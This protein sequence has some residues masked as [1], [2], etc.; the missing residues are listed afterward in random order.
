MMDP[1]IRVV[2]LFYLL[3]NEQCKQ[4]FQYSKKC[5]YV[6]VCTS[7]FDKKFS[8]VEVL[9]SVW[10]HDFNSMEQGRGEKSF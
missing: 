2:S 7:A 5:V 8:I 4:I 3:C 10:H 6:R 9:I 1:S